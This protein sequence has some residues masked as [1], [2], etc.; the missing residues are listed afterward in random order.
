MAHAVRTGARAP[1]TDRFTLARLLR[2]REA[3]VFIALLVL[4]LF[5]SFATDGFLTSLNLLNVGRQISLLGIMAVGMTFVLIAGEVDLSVGST[6]A[7]SGLSTGMLIIAGWALLPAICVGLATGVVIGLING[8]LSTYGRLPSLIATLG[9]LSIVRGAALILTNGQPV[10]VNARNGA[11]PD[12]L[13][14]F[15][16]MGQGYLFT[17]IP[18]QLVFLVIV[19]VL[20]WLV[21]SFSNFGFRVYAV[22]GSAKAARVSGISVNKVKISAFILMGVLAAFAGI[23]GLAFLPSSQ[24]GRTGLGLELDVIAATIVGGASLSGGEGTILGTILGVLIIGV[25]RN[26]LVLLGV[27]PFVQEL[28]IGLVIIIAV[29]IDKWSTRRA[30]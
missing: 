4:C 30:G 7:F 2:A 27:S 28:M 23:L 17:I 11:L 6:Y 5:L 18:M 16:F 1:A 9:M 20:A 3:G 8:V 14:A 13:Q 12:V 25:M 22:G 29:G 19:A 24:A 15:S 21:L 10:T 26:G